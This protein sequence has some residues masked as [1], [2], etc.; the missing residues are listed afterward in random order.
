MSLFLFLCCVMSLSNLD[1]LTK[2]P[3]KICYARKATV[4]FLLPEQKIC[5]WWHWKCSMPRWWFF[6]YLAP[7]IYMMYRTTK[8]PQTATIPPNPYLTTKQENVKTSLIQNT[9]KLT[10]STAGGKRHKKYAE[11]SHFK[12][13][14][15]QTGKKQQSG[16]QFKTSW[17][18]EKHRGREY[19]GQSQS[20]LKNLRI[21]RDNSQRNEQQ[22]VWKL[23]KKKQ[24]N[25]NSKIKKKPHTTSQVQN[26]K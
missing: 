24:Q 12:K 18:W 14:T 17:H 9:R 4:K 8:I 13:Y 21:K 26:M 6:F 5:D 19:R 11:K 15:K 16:I 1:K 7:L 10:N 3:V 23:H 22:H 25:S 20:T 2:R